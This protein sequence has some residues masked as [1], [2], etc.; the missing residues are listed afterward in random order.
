MHDMKFIAGTNAQRSVALLLAQFLLA[1]C[2]ATTGPATPVAQ[3]E[4]QESVGFTISEEAR[5][6]GDVRE[7]YRQALQ[8]LEQGDLDGGVR[9]LDAVVEAAPQLSAPRI[10]RGIALRMAGRPD[11]AVE[12][13]IGALELN[14]RHPIAHNE[15]GIVYRQTGRFAE[16]K[17]SYEAAL[18][19]YP[20]FHFARRNLAVLCDLYLAD[21]E[22]AMQNYEAYM[23]TVFEDAEVTMWMQDL[24]Y[25]MDSGGE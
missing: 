21:L 24:R 19:I 12:S 3:I 1:G 15:L 14:P 10:D 18:A 25:R 20:G 2:L 16:A 13:L 9:L 8:L 5:V 4:I 22:C 17:Q 23:T 11:E 7:D 6:S